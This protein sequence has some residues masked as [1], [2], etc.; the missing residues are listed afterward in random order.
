MSDFYQRGP[1]IDQDSIHNAKAT[2]AGIGSVTLQAV[3]SLQYRCRV[4]LEC[5]AEA[6]I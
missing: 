3:A 6:K 1:I 4:F 2:F 5:L